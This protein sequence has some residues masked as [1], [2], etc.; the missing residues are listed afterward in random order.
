MKRTSCLTSLLLLLLF[1]LPFSLTSQNLLLQRSSVNAGGGTQ[2]ARM[3][4]KPLLVQ[5]SIGQPGPVG[6]SFS[7]NHLLRQG[8]LQPMQ[9]LKIKKSGPNSPLRVFPNPFHNGLSLSLPDTLTGERLISLSDMYG[10][11]V[12]SSQEA[13]SVML[14]IDLSSLAPGLY[15][16]RVSAGTQR[17]SS[18]LIKE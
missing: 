10:R 13:E 1:L 3:Q 9:G 12:F 14:T 16:L 15:L 2:P 7:G 18:L 4:G 5:Q 17:F 6:L 11:M 8:F